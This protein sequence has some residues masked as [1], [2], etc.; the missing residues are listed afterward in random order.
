[1][2]NLNVNE[3]LQRKMELVPKEAFKL[4]HSLSTIEHHHIAIYI[5]LIF[6]MVISI[7]HFVK[8]WQGTQ[9]RQRGHNTPANSATVASQPFTININDC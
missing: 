4:P 2:L 7:I 1:M 9:Q 8:K 5:G 6:I 3:L